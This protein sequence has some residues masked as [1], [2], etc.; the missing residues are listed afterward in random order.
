MSPIFIAGMVF[1]MARDLGSIGVRFLIDVFL[2]L[3]R[4]DFRASWT[5]SFWLALAAFMLTTVVVTGLLRRLRDLA[6]RHLEQVKL[7][8]LTH[9]SIFVRDCDD[10]IV[11]WNRGAEELYG[12]RLE[13]TQ[14][15]RFSSG[16]ARGVV[17]PLPPGGYRPDR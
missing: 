17:N 16:R 3:K 1:T 7:L 15:G 2:I 10:M 13:E 6:E 9:D 14:H 8:E 12:W 5:L 11:F 4:D